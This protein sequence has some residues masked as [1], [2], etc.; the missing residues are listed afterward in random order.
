[1]GRLVL[2][3]VM[4]SGS[5]GVKRTLEPVCAGRGKPSLAIRP[6]QSNPENQA[7]GNSYRHSDADVSD[8]RTYAYACT[9]SD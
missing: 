7:Y 9:D 4:R 8:C 1:M 3:T 5:G 6:A 2:A